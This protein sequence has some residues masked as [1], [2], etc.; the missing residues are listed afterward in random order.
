MLQW[1][2]NN[3]KFVEK[4]R[5][6]TEFLYFLGLILLLIIFAYGVYI[7]FLGFYR[8]DWFMIWGYMVKGP[9]VFVTMYGKE[10]PLMGYLYS[11]LYPLLGSAPWAWA[12]YAFI[13]RLACTLVL[14]KLVKHL[15]PELRWIALVSALLFAIYPGFLEQTQPNT[16]QMHLLGILLALLS[17][18]L[19]V[20]AIQT[21]S[22]VKGYGFRSLSLIFTALYP[23]TMEYYIGL[24][25]LRLAILWFVLKKHCSLS[26]RSLI[27]CFLREWL[28]HMVVIAGFFYW[29]LFLFVTDRP[30]LNTERLIAIYSAQWFSSLLRF[31][32]ELGRDIIEVIFMAWVVPLYNHWYFGDYK[33]FLLGVLLSLLS[34]GAFLAFWPIANRKDKN[35]DNP[36]KLMSE[37]KAGLAIGLIG[38]LSALIPVVATLQEVRFAIRDDRYSLPASLGVAIFLACLLGLSVKNHQRKWIFGALIFSSILTHYQSSRYMID[39]WNVQRQ[40]WWQLSWRAPNI[41]RNTLLMVN[42]PSPFY[43]IE[44]YE[45]WGA[46]NLIFYPDQARPRITGELIQQDPVNLLVWRGKNTRHYRGIYLFRDYNNPLVVSMPTLDSCVHVFDGAMVE[47]STYEEPLVRIAATYSNLDRVLINEPFSKPDQRIFG[48]EP[49]HSWCYYYQKASFYRQKGDWDSIISLYQTVEEQRLMPWDSFEWLPFYVAFVMKGE[50][51]K[52]AEI[53]AHLRSNPSLVASLCKGWVEAKTSHQV[54]QIARL[55]THLCNSPVQ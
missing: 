4:F 31:L 12:V 52:A 40:V 45:I 17:M 28:P 38:I 29:R 41:K 42:L 49:P 14:F 36:I 46:S 7:P 3:E 30:T 18:L 43:F 37:M 39:F 47:T 44:G 9:M 32:V 11:A 35:S 25:G 10:R 1:L 51:Q 6:R 53:A 13:L 21:S 22:R 33:V 8:E 50:E 16:F 15:W 5:V 55:S 2:I 20:M 19:M 54:E 34:A 26:G 27:G 23:F 48:K 24:E